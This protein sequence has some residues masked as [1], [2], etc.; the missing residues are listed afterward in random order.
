MY[1]IGTHHTSTPNPEL[2]VFAPKMGPSQILDPHPTVHLASTS[3]IP[4]SHASYSTSISSSVYVFASSSPAHPDLVVLGGSC[5]PS[6]SRRMQSSDYIHVIMLLCYPYHT[7]VGFG[8]RLPADPWNL[9]VTKIPPFRGVQD[10]T[11]STAL[12]RVVTHM[13]Y[14]STPHTP[15]DVHV[16]ML[17]ALSHHPP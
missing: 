14:I 12:T 17:Y 11:M 9:T 5:A 16:S 6:A 13:Q 1:R 8:T 2:A 15:C 4:H 10:V 7:T 3:R